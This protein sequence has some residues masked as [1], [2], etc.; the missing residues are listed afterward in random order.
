MPAPACA[1]PGS[2]ALC[3]VVPANAVAMAIV[4]AQTT[5]LGRIM[6]ISPVD[7][8]LLTATCCR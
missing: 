4:H 8:P 2:P 1:S 6:I 7:Y 3:I 5:V